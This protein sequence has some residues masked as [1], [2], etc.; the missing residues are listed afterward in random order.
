MELFAFWLMGKYRHTFLTIPKGSISLYKLIT[1]LTTPPN[2]YTLPFHKNS[3]PGY[4]L[5]T[6]NNYILDVTQNQKTLDV[7]SFQQ[8][9]YS[10]FLICNGAVVD[11]K[12][13]SVQ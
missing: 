13:L 10:V 3:Y 8:G 7:S 9:I 2:F 5:A 12:Q 6:I 4:F 11:M 1:K